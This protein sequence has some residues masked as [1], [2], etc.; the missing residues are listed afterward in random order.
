MY[1][2]ECL[3]DELIHLI[4]QYYIFGL[5]GR[6]VIKQLKEIIEF[7]RGEPGLILLTENWYELVDEY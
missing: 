5:R 6:L 7:S 3:P 1:L 4:F 2:L